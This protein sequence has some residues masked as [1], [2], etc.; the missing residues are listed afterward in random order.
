MINSRGKICLF[1]NPDFEYSSD[2]SDFIRYAC[3]EC[4]NDD[5]DEYEETR[6]RRI[7][8]QNEF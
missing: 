4:D 1:C 8:E 5:I 6:R 7:A 3:E 2:D